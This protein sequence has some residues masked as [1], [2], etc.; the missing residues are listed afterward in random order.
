MKHLRRITVAGFMIIML[1]AVGMIAA[2]E[3]AP[4]EGFDAYLVYTAAGV[5]DPDDPNYEAPDGMFFQREIMGRTDA[6]IE[7]NKQDAIAFFIERFGVDPTDNADVSFTDSSFMVDPRNEYRAYVVSGH[8]VPAEGWVIRDGGWSVRITNPDGITLGGEFAGEHAPAGSSFF[9]GDY[10]IDVPG[11]DPIIIHY[12]SAFIASPNASGTFAFRCEV[13]SEDFGT[14][15]A[16]GISA[17]QTT[18][19]GLRHA[20]IRNILTFPGLGGE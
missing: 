12:Q 4:P 7:Q 3:V 15:L 2:Q 8:E 20:N 6:E 5:Y 1:F 13:I 18:E 16:Q 19:D 9:F 11:E 10:N 17:P 14:G